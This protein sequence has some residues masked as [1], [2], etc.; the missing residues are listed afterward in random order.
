MNEDDGKE[1]I[2]RIV[3]LGFNGLTLGGARNFGEAKRM[4][5]ASIP[6]SLHRHYGGIGTEGQAL[7]YDS[8]PDDLL[9]TYKD[10]LQPRGE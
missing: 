9:D 5:L 10:Q 2:A 3:V 4:Q 7:F 1:G 8:I 6:Q